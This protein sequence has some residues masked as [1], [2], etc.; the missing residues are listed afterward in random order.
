METLFPS[1]MVYDDEKDICTL[2]FKSVLFTDTQMGITPLSYFVERASL[3]TGKRTCTNP[4]WPRR[5]SGLSKWN[6]SHAVKSFR[7]PI[8]ETAIGIG[9]WKTEARRMGRKP[10]QLPLSPP[11]TLVT[12]V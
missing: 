11:V 9:S 7:W 6:K 5:G 8:F 4:G 2:L 3:S 10:E 1:K 12:S